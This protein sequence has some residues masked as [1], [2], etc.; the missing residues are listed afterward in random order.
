[1]VSLK[2]VTFSTSGRESSCCEINK[3]LFPEAS[4]M[5]KTALYTILQCHGLTS[6]TCIQSVI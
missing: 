1:M 3:Y 2:D 5:G 6:D 4:N